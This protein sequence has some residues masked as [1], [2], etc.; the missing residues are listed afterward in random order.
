M[1]DLFESSVITTKETYLSTNF[2]AIEM[3]DFIDAKVL[4]S[5]MSSIFYQLQLEVYCKNQGGIQR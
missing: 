1:S 3:G 2:I 4:A 5:W